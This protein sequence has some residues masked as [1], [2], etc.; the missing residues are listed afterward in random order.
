MCCISP[1]ANTINFDGMVFSE[2][3]TSTYTVNHDCTY[4]EETTLADGSV[5]H[6]AGIGT[7]E[8][9]HQEVHFIST[10]NVQVSMGTMKKT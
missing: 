7:A 4:S 6:V 9:I 2:A 10:D 1:F 3:G 5:L 8:G